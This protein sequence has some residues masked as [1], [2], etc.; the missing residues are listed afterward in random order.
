MKKLLNVLFILFTA[1]V[2]SCTG[3][4]AAKQS[5][6]LQSPI[7][8]ITK[9]VIDG[10]VQKLAINYDDTLFNVENTGHTIEF[11]PNDLFENHIVLDGVKYILQQVHFHSPSEHQIDGK[12]AELEIHFV[13][14]NSAGDISVIA[15]FVNSGSENAVLKE[16]FSKLPKTKTNE[17][18]I[19]ELSKIINLGNLFAGNKNMYCYDGSLTTAPYTEIVKWNIAL[20]PAE[21]SKEQIAAFT[22]IYKNNNRPIQALNARVVGLSKVN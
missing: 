7:N 8:I 5:G 6:V 13:H 22:S 9:D 18:T 14:K 4:Q 1:F 11:I 20:K 17:A 2:I 21:F 3:T 19:V 16:M 10:F 12:S 15:L